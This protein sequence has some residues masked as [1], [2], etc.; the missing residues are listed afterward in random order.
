MEEDRL[1]VLALIRPDGSDEAHFVVN[2]EF[3]E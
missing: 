3:A 2:E 1:D